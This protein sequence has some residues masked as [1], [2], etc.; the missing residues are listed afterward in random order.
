MNDVNNLTY[1]RMWDR[2]GCLYLL[3]PGQEHSL[4][5]H[6][7]AY[8]DA[9]AH[10]DTLISLSTIEG[11]TMVV[12]AS[13]VTSW[14]LSTPETRA[15]WA[16]IDAELEAEAERLREQFATPEWKEGGES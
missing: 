6:V 11:G 14:C 10:R 3:S 5:A 7:S 12:L 4:D 8:H 13:T 15:V 2:L 1:L 16:R 9:G